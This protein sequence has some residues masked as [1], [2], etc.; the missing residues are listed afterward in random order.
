MGMV[1]VDNLEV[2]MVLSEDV[3]DISSRLLLTKGQKIQSNH[4]RIFKIW[5]ITEVSVVE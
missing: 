3:K 2:G 5:G 1:H 4:I